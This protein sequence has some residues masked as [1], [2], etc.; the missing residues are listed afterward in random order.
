MLSDEENVFK[1]HGLQ[2]SIAPGDDED[3][4]APHCT[5]SASSA[6]P[7]VARYFPGMQCTQRVA[8]LTDAYF[9]ASHGVHGDDP[10]LSLYLPASHG[11]Q[12]P[13]LGP[14]IV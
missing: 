7:C 10:E 2:T 12:L 1:G 6:L 14:D 13:P 4:P 9:P 5:Q 11:T 8:P 3:V